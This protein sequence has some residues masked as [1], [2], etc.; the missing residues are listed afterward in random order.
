MTSRQREW[1]DEEARV[2][3][4]GLAERAADERAADLD[5]HSDLFLIGKRGIDL[6][7]SAA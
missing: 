1:V 4:Q 2:S 5:R 6:T 3:E 7:V